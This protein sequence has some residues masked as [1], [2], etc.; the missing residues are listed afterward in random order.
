[1][2]PVTL[3]TDD[4]EIFAGGDAVT[5]PKTVIEAIEAGKQA[6]RSIDR[7][8]QGRDLRGGRGIRERAVQNV[9]TEGYDRI[10]RERMPRL[11]PKNRILGF[12][13]VQLGFS[14]D[15]AVAEATRCLS[16]GVCAE[17]Y[18]CVE[19][20]GANAVTMDTHGEC[21]ESMEIEAGAAILAP[22]FQAFDPSGHA[23]YAYARH[24]NVITSM[25]FERILSASG[26]TMGRLVRPS[27]KRE[28]EKIAWIQC[29]GSRDVHHCDHG[30][31]SSVC[32]MYAIKEAVIAQE[33]A[34]AFLDCAIFFMDMRT[35]GKDFERYYNDAKEK[36][37]VRF[38]R[39]RVP[40]IEAVAGSDHLVIPY[41]NDQGEVIEE[42]F[43]MVVLSVGIEISPESSALAE[44]FRI[45]LTEGRFSQTD[46]FD[47][48]ATSR[49][50]VFSCGAFHGPMDIPQSVVEAGSAAA[51]AGALLS[52]SRHTLTVK[53]E[54]P[55]ERDIEGAPP[56][57][58]VFICH[59]GINISGVVDIDSVRDYA[60]TLPYVTYVE[61][62][63]YT[64]SQDTQETM[65][66]M[67]EEHH[68]NRM[69]VAACTPKTHEALFQ[70]TMV[71][72]GLNKYLFE[73]TNIRNQDSWVHKSDPRVA[74]EKAKDLLRMAVSKAALTEPLKE[75]EL[76]IVPKA[77]VIGGG[78]AGMAAAENLSDQGY[79]VYLVERDSH[80]GGTARRLFRTWK[81]ENIGEALDA[82]IQRVLSDPKIEVWLDTEI[83]SVEGFVGNY[84][85]IVARGGQEHSLEHGVAVVATGASESRP[86]EYL[87]GRDPRVMTHLELDEK[88]RE[89]DPSLKNMK[90]A[91]FVQCVGS[92][93]PQR[94]WCSRVCCTH[95]VE[96]ALHLKRI[97][98]KAAIYVL[99]RDIRTY[100]EREYLFR[101]ARK[102]G[103]LFIRF[104]VDDKPKV[105]A[106]NEGLYI[107]LFDPI[108]GDRVMI[109]SDLLALA[110]AIIPHQNERLAQFFKVA[111]NQDG[112]FQEAHAKLGP[113][114]FATE[115]VF[116]CGMAHYP[117][118][119]DESVAQALAASSRAV[120]LLAG[121][122]I[123]VSG[124][125]A[126]VDATVC[127]G[128]GVCTEICPYGAPA[129]AQKGSSEG[130]VEINPVLCK[131]CGLCV[132]S[133]RS[134]AINLKGFGE[135]QIMAMI[136]EV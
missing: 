122:R 70:A 78:I 1:V 65:V 50:G 95:A 76:G 86:E 28:P 22:G 44:K 64:C 45:D 21:T 10:P 100:G 39:S 135:E 54:I 6:A 119:I 108:V 35:H 19:V 31:C 58:G 110:P 103:V 120:T 46:T 52:E 32:C 117:K 109:R 5:G 93:E 79:P 66:K 43:D 11:D 9:D 97:N 81:G 20:C 68:L 27:D 124:M 83:A 90:T 24:P 18:Q 130:R 13:E 37:G 118:T 7:F 102:A 129:F 96:S 14:E 61:D 55:Q 23:A 98:P 123:R 4:P 125:V 62:N 57:I 2:N 94:P 114:Q 33:H 133:C 91:V 87:Y 30:Y 12:S 47:P 107:E 77:L 49:K 82:L 25:E 116:L 34:K 69:V 41:T 112:F 26:P 60:A 36:H 84:R 51:R 40:T 15:Q 56:R 128:C 72:A 48:V 74:T 136:N 63:L 85:S 88:L 101:E 89:E 105:S 121:E 38:I 104:S 29:V 113:S 115:G 75:A 16:C 99:Y 8:L 134:G 131:G 126:V 42:A 106:H 71:S 17:C 59:C 111:L 3:Q 127:S 67:I 53:E 132:S 80:L 73:M 92:R